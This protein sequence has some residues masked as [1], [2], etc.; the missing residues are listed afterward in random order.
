MKDLL[1]ALAQSLVE[2]PDEVKVEEQV[3]EDGT[4]VFYLRVADGDMGRVIGKQG[5]IAKAIRTLLRAA[6]TRED[7]KVSVEIVD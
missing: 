7:K 3:A 6:A 4:I 5:R 2:K 1:I